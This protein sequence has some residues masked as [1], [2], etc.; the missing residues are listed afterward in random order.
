MQSSTQLLPA[1]GKM[2]SG[3]L[4][5]DGNKDSNIFDGSCMS[6]NASDSDPWLAID[7]G[8]PTIVTGI[9]YT[10]MMFT[11]GTY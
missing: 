10:N 3:S 6:T 1:T 8:K 11:N 4:A 5:V 2:M 7:L 9:S